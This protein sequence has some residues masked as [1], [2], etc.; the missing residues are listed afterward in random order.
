MLQFLYHVPDR[1]RA[2]QELSR[3]VGVIF[4]A[5]LVAD[6]ETA[7]YVRKPLDWAPTP[8]HPLRKYFREE[9]I[10]ANLD[11][12]I[13][14]QQADGGWHITWPAVSP[15][16]KLEWGGWITLEKLRMLQANGRLDR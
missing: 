14:E 11:K 10:Q 7:G 15:S 6:V 8:E 4:S 1:E 13:E 9:D 2:E 5:D 3:L 12:V 16:C